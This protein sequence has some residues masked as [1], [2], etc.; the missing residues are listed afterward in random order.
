M[1]GDARRKDATVHEVHQQHPGAQDTHYPSS[2][3]IIKQHYQTQACAWDIPTGLSQELNCP[4]SPAAPSSPATGDLRFQIFYLLSNTH[5]PQHLH[6]LGQTWAFPPGES[7]L[8][9][10]K[11]HL[12]NK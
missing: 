8:T 3:G 10:G 9:S 5:T 4:S 2:S 7:A 12:G 6:A 11:Y 1:P